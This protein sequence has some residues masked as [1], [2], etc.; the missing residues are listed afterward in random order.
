MGGVGV[1]RIWVSSFSG[2]SPRKCTSA[3]ITLKRSY[4]E[5][6]RLFLF[7]GFLFLIF[8][9]SNPDSLVPPTLEATLI[10]DSFLE[11]CLLVEAQKTSCGIKVIVMSN[12]ILNEP[13]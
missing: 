6:V 4:A 12:G 9:L 5:S 11:C 1:H 7:M 10:N 8:F 13:A 2:A 3:R